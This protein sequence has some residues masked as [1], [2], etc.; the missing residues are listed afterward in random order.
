MKKEIN[1]S[2]IINASTARVWEV[3]TDFENY[4]Q[5][6]PFIK[7]IEGTVQLGNTIKVTVAGASFKPK[8][9]VFAEMRELKWLGHFLV[10][11]LFDGEHCFELQKLS[12]GRTRFL[13]SEK[14]HG[15]L[16]PLMVKKLDTE[17]FAGFEA[18]NTALKN[19]VERII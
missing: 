10:K 5:W 15:L 14:F 7:S 9:L 13:H 11:G 1:T 8:V 18:M 12:Y 3:L 4:H 16:L 17:I 19:R 6:N 2:I